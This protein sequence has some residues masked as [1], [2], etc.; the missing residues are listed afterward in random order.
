M[1]HWP[2]SDK[3]SQVYCLNR[4]RNVDS[5]FYLP[6]FLVVSLSKWARLLGWERNLICV[7]KVVSLSY[8]P[9][10][11][12]RL[13]TGL[14]Q[15][16]FQRGCLAVFL[17]LSRDTRDR[18]HFCPFSRNWVQTLCLPTQ[19]IR[20]HGP[21]KDWHGGHVQLQP[22]TSAL[23]HLYSKLCRGLEGL[24]QQCFFTHSGRLS[25]IFRKHYYF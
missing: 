6:V 11:T 25:Q 8:F 17:K 14:L 3:K 18:I 24:P 22:V 13:V 15:A 7:S 9:A 2:C 20:P 16:Y 4:R 19:P 10:K 23:S 5:A 12:Q 21:G 1:G